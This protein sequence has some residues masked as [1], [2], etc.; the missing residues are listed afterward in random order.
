MII[1]KVGNLEVWVQRN[2]SD[3][4]VSVKEGN[5]VKISDVYFGGRVENII[6]D[7]L[8]KLDIYTEEWLWLMVPDLEKTEGNNYKDKDD[9]FLQIGKSQY[10][11]HLTDKE[12]KARER[13]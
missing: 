8:Q 6:A 5:K 13:K 9:Y 11:K 7:I 10:Y 4:S 12:W 3:F 1:E 2:P